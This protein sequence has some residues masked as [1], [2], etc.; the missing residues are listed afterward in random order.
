MRVVGSVIAFFNGLFLAQVLRYE[1]PLM[2]LALTMISIA[3]GCMWTAIYLRSAM[4]RLERTS[5]QF[6]DD[7]KLAR[8][9]KTLLRQHI[10][11]LL[12]ER[13]T[14]T[15][16]KGATREPHTAPLADPGAG[17]DGDERVREPGAGD[18]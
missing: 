13:E 14:L 6:L 8:I 9:E 2:V 4:N 10:A 5:Q 15:P 7:L 18:A 17:P 1:R 16:D 3:D 11:M 12:L